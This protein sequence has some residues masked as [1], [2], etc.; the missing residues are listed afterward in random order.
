MGECGTVVTSILRCLLLMDAN[1]LLYVLLFGWD[2]SAKGEQYLQGSV[3]REQRDT[4]E[5]VQ[6]RRQHIVVAAF[7]LVHRGHKRGDIYGA[8]GETV[9]CGLGRRRDISRR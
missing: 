9:G 1:V 5:H 7:H 2:E 8:L 6:D 4:P 3:D